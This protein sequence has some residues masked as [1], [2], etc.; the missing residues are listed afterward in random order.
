MGP[1]LSGVFGFC[2]CFGFLLSVEFVL[3]RLLIRDLQ[4]MTVSLIPLLP[5]IW[6]IDLRLELQMW[7]VW[8][9]KLRY[10]N[11][12]QLEFGL[13]L[14]HTYLTEANMNPVR[15]AI[16]QMGRAVGR[17]LRT[18]FGA[19]APSRLIDSFAGSWTGVGTVFD[20][21]S[22]SVDVPWPD[23]VYTSGRALISSHFVG[24]THLVVGTVYEAAQSPSFRD[25]LGITQDSAAF[26]CG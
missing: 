19:P 20:Y 2:F 23:G 7:L 4:L 12:F 16:K 17:S 6:D 9:T 22:C 10:L 1:L 15:M 18:V 25:P 8:P 3:G 14:K 13:S 5:P 26:C 24:D 11:P 21:P